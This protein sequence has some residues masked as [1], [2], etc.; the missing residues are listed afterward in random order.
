MVLTFMTNYVARQTDSTQFYLYGI[1][2]VKFYN[3]NSRV[4]IE[5][6][7]GISLGL[8]DSCL[9]SINLS[10]GTYEAE[11]GNNALH[12][13]GRDYPIDQN[14][15]EIFNTKFGHLKMEAEFHDN[16]N[17]DEFDNSQF[18][19]SYSGAR[20]YMAFKDVKDVSLLNNE[21]INNK[22]W[23]SNQSIAL[24]FQDC[25]GAIVVGNKILSSK[26]G[27]ISGVHILTS[28]QINV[29]SNVMEITEIAPVLFPSRGILAQEVS[30]SNFVNNTINRFG[31][32]FEFYEQSNFSAQVSHFNENKVFNCSYG[33]S[34]APEL[35]PMLNTDPTLNSS[36]DELEV[37]LEC[38]DFDNCHYG[39]VSFGNLRYQVGTVD[40]GNTFNTFDY[41]LYYHHPSS[42]SHWPYKKLSSYTLT[43]PLGAHSINGQVY[44]FSKRY[45]IVS[46]Y[47][48]CPPSPFDVFSSRPILNKIDFSI[49]PNP[50][51]DNIN[52][53][54]S[55]QVRTL[56]IYDV[57][58]KMVL[59]INGNTNQINLEG[60]LDGAYVISMEAENGHVA[61]AHFIVLKK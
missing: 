42:L 13:I 11:F 12:V 61:S 59:E 55:E 24:Q 20:P 56:R 7:D 52:I 44:S 37:E 9:T 5:F 45:Q 39:I 23:Q 30:N 34:I 28:S 18:A 4:Y 26:Q 53:S 14:K 35:H 1:N 16:C 41:D 15:I 36:L 48:A 29:N 32:G 60:F 25:N 54:S 49:Y 2:T 22:F 50:A 17:Y 38:N 21:I 57:L 33:T 3:N 10:G 46:S 6:V 27:F 47:A 43:W 51:S 19:L 40:P 58:G 31:T 8:R